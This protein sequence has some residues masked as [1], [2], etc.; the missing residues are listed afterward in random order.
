MI[1]RVKVHLEK[2]W[3]SKR[4][5]TEGGAAIPLK[6]TRCAFRNQDKSKQKSAIVSHTVMDIKDWT[7]HRAIEVKV[8]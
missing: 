1:F 2:G 6:T 4:M 8:P 7:L 3:N 5:I